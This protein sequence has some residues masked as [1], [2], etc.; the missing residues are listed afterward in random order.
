LRGL[1]HMTAELNARLNRQLQDEHGISLADY[2]VL[3]R[4]SETPG[5]GL[6]ARD[7]EAT[8]SWEQSRLSHQLTRMQRRGLV[9]RHDC[10]TDRRGA[11]FAITDA[12][13]AAIEDA[14]PGHV[15]AVRRML[16]DHLGT[17]DVT[18]LE[19]LTARVNDHLGATSRDDPFR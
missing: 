6:R 13:R 12:G 5:G 2:E 16:F 15:E 9:E 1:I 7:L 10:L 14:A 18:W 3:A 17:E 11:T 8:L 4:L 19:G